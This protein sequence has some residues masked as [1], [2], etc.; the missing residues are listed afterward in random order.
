MKKENQK[1]KEY[2]TNFGSFSLHLFLSLSIKF[3][4]A[5]AL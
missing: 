5:Y 2:E 1:K 3:H 4:I